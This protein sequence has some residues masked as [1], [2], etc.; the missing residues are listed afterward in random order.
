MP[1]RVLALPVEKPLLGW[2]GVACFFEDHVLAPA[3]VFD[4]FRVLL[5]DRVQLSIDAAR[6]C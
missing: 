6:R 1:E 2:L 4:I 5:V 3:V